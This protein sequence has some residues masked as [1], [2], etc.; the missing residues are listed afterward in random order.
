M[1][2]RDYIDKKLYEN[3]VD[4]LDYIFGID[5]INPNLI[6]LLGFVI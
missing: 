3:S 6:T 1:H 4:F 2:K 5:N